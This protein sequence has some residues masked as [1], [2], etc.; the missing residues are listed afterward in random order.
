MLL[1]R[2]SAWSLSRPMRARAVEPLTVEKSFGR[3]VTVGE[4]RARLRLIAATLKSLLTSIEMAGACSVRDCGTSTVGKR[5]LPLSRARGSRFMSSASVLAP[6]SRLCSKRWVR[7]FR[8]IDIPHLAAPRTI[9][10]ALQRKD[11]NQ[12]R[13]LPTNSPH[14]A[15]FVSA[16]TDQM[17]HTRDNPQVA[18]T[19]S[20]HS[21]LKRLQGR[22]HHP[23]RATR[24][25]FEGLVCLATHA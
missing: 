12:L 6:S 24:P 4:V 18:A 13:L 9:A 14:R 20:L 10:N 11:A 23:H 19:K 15:A 2:A 8:M 16:Q 25:C 17:A 22:W 1:N 21:V 3:T 7:S 5:P